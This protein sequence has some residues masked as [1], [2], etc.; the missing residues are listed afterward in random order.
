[1]CTGGKCPPCNG[2]EAGNGAGFI[3][4]AGGGGAGGKFMLM[5]MPGGFI[6]P[7][8]PGIPGGGGGQDPWKFGGGGGGAV[9]GIIPGGDI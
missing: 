9:P 2:N 7:G 3:P 8:I 1:M 6:I 4:D 5:F